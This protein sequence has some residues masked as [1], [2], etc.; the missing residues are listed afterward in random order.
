MAESIAEE[1]AP[2][3]H[4]V[5]TEFDGKAATYESGRLAGWYKA[6]AMLLLAILGKE[7]PP[8]RVLDIGCGTGFLLRELARRNPGMSGMG[9]DLS[10][11]MI[12]AARMAAWREG[13][14]GL[15]FRQ[16]DWEDEEGVAQTQGSFDT[17]VCANCLHYFDAPVAAIERMRGMLGPGGRLLILDRAADGSPATL[18]WHFAHRFLIHDHV[19]FYTATQLQS[20]A[21][22]AG[23]PQAEVAARVRRILWEGK[24]NTSLAIIRAEAPQ[25]PHHPPGQE[26]S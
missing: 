15:T 20:F 5:E 4:P 12:E 19:R 23:F 17:V 1:E 6:H 18:L 25:E 9:I 14:D 16:I 21:V 13:I 7:A 22:A 26:S 11:G 24:L 10:G 2:A 3:R 8:R